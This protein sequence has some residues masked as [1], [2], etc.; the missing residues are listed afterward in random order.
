M[1]RKQVLWVCK[2]TR[3]PF[4]TVE[5]RKSVEYIA[6]DRGVEMYMYVCIAMV[7]T[8]V[9]RGMCALGVLRGMCAYQWV[10]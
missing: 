7:C 2:Y 3:T 10:C 5:V 8:R 4:R 1:V 9:L 6:L